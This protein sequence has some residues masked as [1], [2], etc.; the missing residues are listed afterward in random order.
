MNWLL[1]VYSKSCVKR[2]LS[3]R[4]Q[5]GF[6]YQLMLNVGHKYC[7]MLQGEHS[8]ILLTFMKHLFVIK[9]FVLS[10]FEWL[11]YSG[12]TVHIFI[13]NWTAL[14]DWIRG[15]EKIMSESV[16]SDLGLTSWRLCCLFVLFNS[17][18]PINN[19]S[20]KQGRVFLGWTITKL[21]LMCLAQGHNAVTQVRLEPMTP[22]LQ[23]IE[24]ELCYA[25]HLHSIYEFPL[26]RKV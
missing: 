14:L 24:V 18:R 10:N 6:Q 25:D 7:R 1:S 19:L 9:I 23:S 3:K 17:L 15:R 20:V 16:C 12:F 4:P 5:I 8:A 13:S 22:R 2:P 11:F 26:K 21:G